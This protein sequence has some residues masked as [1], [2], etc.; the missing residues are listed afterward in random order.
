MCHVNDHIDVHTVTTPLC[1]VCMKT[2]I[3]R[4]SL[5]VGLTIYVFRTASH[6][7]RLYT[8]SPSVNDPR[9]ENMKLPDNDPKRHRIEIMFSPGCSFN[10]FDG[11][12]YTPEYAAIKEPRVPATSHVRQRAQARSQHPEVPPGTAP[13]LLPPA[14]PLV[15]AENLT[16]EQVEDF[17]GSAI[18]V[19]GRHPYD[20]TTTDADGGAD[21]ESVGSSTPMVSMENAV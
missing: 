19:A 4:G 18:T 21:G 6:T 2:D 5:R 17:F 3:R 15:L 14:Q 12:P 9:F 20:D 8:A 10:P 11:S 1:P 16:L 7:I 13:P